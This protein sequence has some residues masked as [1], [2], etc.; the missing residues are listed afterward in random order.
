MALPVIAAAAIPAV[1]S[2]VGGVLQGIGNQRAARAAMQ[3][4]RMG[5]DENRRLSAGQR[6]EQTALQQPWMAGGTQAFDELGQFRMREADPY[7][8]QQFGGV[9]MSQDPGV[10]YRMQQAVKGMDTSAAARGNLFG[11]PQQKAMAAHMQNLASQ[12]FNNAY[13]RQYGQF[14]D[15]ENARR[16]QFNTEADRTM[17]YD[18]F[19]MTQLDNLAGRGQ[20]ATNTLSAAQ[21]DIGARELQNQMT[22]RGAQANTAGTRAGGPWATAGGV[23]QSLGNMGGD[24]ASYYMR[25]K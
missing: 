21:G 18:T 17:D 3:Q 16:E 24:I 1:G 19:R 7:S 10:A 6:G 22:L 13:G 15:E 2:M 4:T 5:M 9:D 25:K 14:S 20:T 23:A 12:E 11:G 8:G